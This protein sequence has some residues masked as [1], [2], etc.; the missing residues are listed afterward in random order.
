MK[1][2]LIGIVAFFIIIVGALALVPI[3]FKD[4]ISEA[5][6]KGLEK[7]VNADVYF[8]ADKF[9]LSVFK[10]FPNVTATLGDFGVI[11]RA[12]FEGEVLFAASSMQIEVNL[13][14]ILFDDKPSVKGILLDKPI[15][16]I[17]ALEDGTANYDIAIATDEEVT[18]DETEAEFSIG[19][20]H[21]EIIDGYLMVNYKP[22]TYYMELKGIN[23]KG[24]GNFNQEIFDLNTY[25]KADTIVVVYDG[26]TY[27][28][29]N[30]VVA[31]AVIS[32]SEDYSM[33]TFKENQAML[34]DF[35]FS[36]DGWFKM[37]EEDYDMD[38][39]FATK[40]NTFKSL[41]SLMPGM[42]S[43]SFANLKSE[44]ELSFNGMVKGKYSDDIMPAFN[45]ALNVSDGFFQYADLPAPV[46]NIQVDLIVNN[47]DGNIDNTFVH[48]KQMHVDFGNNPFDMSLKIENLKDYRMEGQ[49]NG[50]LNLA[51]LSTMFPIDGLTMRGIFSISANAKGVYDEVKKTIPTLD[52]NMSLSDGYFKSSEFP[53]ALEDLKFNSTVKNSSG[54]LAE[55]VVSVSNFS[56]MLEEERFTAD[57]LLSNLDDYTWDVKANGG[58]D[59]EKITKIFPLEGMTLAGQIKADLKTQGKMSD[60]KAERYDRLPTSGNITITD[61]SYEDVS[62]PYVLKLNSASGNFDPRKI[63]IKDVTGTIGKSDF[64]VN[65][66]II[67]YIGYVFGESELL[68]GSINYTANLLDLNEF[69]GETE[70]AVEEESEEA[71]SVIPIPKNIDFVMKSKINT[72]KIMD[73]A[74]TNAE[75]EIVLRGGI[76]NLNGLKF[77]MLGGTFV[78]AGSYNTQDITKP[79]YDFGMKIDN[80]SIP[81][82]FATFTAVKTFVPIAEKIV[83]NFSTDFKI[84]GLLQQDMMPDLASITGAGLVKIAQAAVKDSHLISGITSITKLEDT[85]EVSLRD[86]IMSAQISDGRLGVKPFDV[87]V[88]N[89]TTTIVG[90]TGMDG[91]I[92]YNLK[93]DVP[94]GKLGA[95]LTGLVSQFTGGTATANPN[96]M[97]PVTIGLG[98]TYANPRPTIIM[99]EQKQQLRDAVTSAAEEKGREM[100]QDALKG[101]EAEKRIGDLLGTK[102]KGTD[103]TGTDST[104]LP[105]TVPITKDEAKEKAE[106][107]AKKLQEEAQ[108]KI[109][110]LLKKKGGGG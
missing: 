72:V 34:N 81:Q 91:S 97:I 61:L 88:G 57:L 6:S 103:S 8:D 19:I 17:I 40:D 50:K 107:E 69:M 99:D 93:M 43:E 95:E 51:E 66:S 44:G 4:K 18:A 36:F 27:L 37:N 31:D 7:S 45:I 70:E 41:L 16:N 84:N 100:L 90:S 39:S 62:L 108:Q 101:S 1:K 64:I 65:G 79:T 74:M 5:I 67:N 58:V 3:L 54:R 35:A 20:D 82:A 47:T 32:I 28:S 25:T 71:Y 33:Y 87:K 10:N 23:H 83:G 96:Q 26:V 110:N 77:N 29:N 38:I 106:E 2:L 85:N 56:M 78:V 68:K 75:G 94:A 73:L 46:S 105:I 60:L 55:T 13:K 89:Y 98:G 9:S 92:S 11:N 52:I 86:V 12:P 63:E 15:I 102:K 109:K 76:A 42:Y 49:A 104:V 14:S 30:T 53:S 22:A 24:N 80:A 21:W 48:L 59:L